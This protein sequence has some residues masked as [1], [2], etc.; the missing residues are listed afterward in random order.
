MKTKDFYSK[1]KEQGKI[2]SPDFDA[3]IESL[4]GDI[5]DA[6]TKAIEDNFLTRERAMSDRQVS[7]DIWGKALVP[8]DKEID[9]ITTFIESLDKGL[10]ND[11]RWMVKDLG[12]DKRVPDTFKQLG[13]IS[14]SLPKI[15]EK[16]KAA[17][18]DDEAT[19]K[20]LAD[21]ER[22]I[23]ELTG[24][25]TEAEKS[26]NDRLEQQ[27]LESEK[28]LN[29]YKIDTQLQSMGNKFTLAEAYEKNR[30]DFTQVF[31]S[32]IKSDN[33]LRL[34]DK[35]EIQVYDRESGKPKFNGNSPVTITSLL[36]EKFKPFLKQSGQA[37]APTQESNHR[38][39]ERKE[40]HRAGS[41][42]T[43]E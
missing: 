5:P 19:K 21:Y 39:P 24:K 32:K 35:N 7:M 38:P 6:V 37:A 42:T 14:Q 25:F 16:V 22:N 3:F 40:G 43:V 33:D 8:V 10:A 4:D 2:D 12:P 30:E 13:K 18:V 15:L 17:P 34:G 23:Q 41:R 20:K 1:L 27:K 28:Y 26:Y 31:L 11:I 9:R 36:E 29:D